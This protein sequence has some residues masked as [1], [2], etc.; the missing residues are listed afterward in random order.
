M[1]LSNECWLKDQCMKYQKQDA[2]CRSDNV[3]CM[4]LF[5]LE[6]L[7]EESLLSKAQWKKEP[8]RLD[9][10]RVDEDIFKALLE[11]QNNIIEFVNNGNNLYLYSHITGNGKT[12]WAVRLIQSYLNSIWTTS[13]LICR[14]LFIS[15]PKYLLALKDNISQY[16]D[17]AHAIKD[18]VYN[19]DLV[20]WDDIGTKTA[21]SFEHENLL[22]II[23]Y[24]MNERKSNIFT[25]NLYPEELKVAAGDRLYSRIVNYST[26]FC[27]RGQDK[28]NIRNAGD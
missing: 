24:R 12:A 5:K 23:D 1:L 28:R 25:S 20:V 8:L 9:E 18:N 22:S 14:A 15:V 11:I 6:Q 13:D 10:S 21:T 26:D 17:Y 2:E 27:F 4:K 3:F 7:F 19:A 16:N